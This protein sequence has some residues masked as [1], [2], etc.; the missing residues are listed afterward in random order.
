M[1]STAWLSVMSTSRRNFIYSVLDRPNVHAAVHPAP[2]DRRRERKS[3][4]AVMRQKKCSTKKKGSGS[5][6]PDEREQG[7][8]APHVRFTVLT[9]AKHPAEVLDGLLGD[10]GRE[11]TATARVSADETN[12]HPAFYR[13]VFACLDQPVTAS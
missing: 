10:D 8:N 7:L 2:R 5:S 12:R 6:A 9:I 1:R 4:H 13:E 3:D 11:A